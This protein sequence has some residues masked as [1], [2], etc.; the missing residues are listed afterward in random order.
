MRAVHTVLAAR[1]TCA[2]ASRTS[3]VS[4]EHL[5]DYF[6]I[7][8]VSCFIWGGVLDSSDLLLSYS[9]IAISYLITNI[10]ISTLF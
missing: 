7:L 9:I 5:Q 10:L 3:W 2:A 6:F 8:V 4:G 1:T